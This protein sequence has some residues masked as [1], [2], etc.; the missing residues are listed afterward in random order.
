MHLKSTL[1]A[2]AKRPEA[3]ALGK[4]KSRSFGSTSTLTSTLHDLQEETRERQQLTPVAI[5]NWLPEP[6]P[7]VH[8]CW[9]R[10]AQSREEERQDKVDIAARMQLLQV[11]ANRRSQGGLCGCPEL[12]GFFLPQGLEQEADR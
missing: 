12:F 4:L 2:H 8:N 5:V 3:R 6:K 1:S 7:V 9:Q 10:A 11:S